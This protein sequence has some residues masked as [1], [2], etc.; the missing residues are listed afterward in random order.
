MPDFPGGMKALMDYLSKNVKYPA[1]AHAILSLIHI[2]KQQYAACIPYSTGSYCNRCSRW[3]LHAS[4]RSWNHTGTGWSYQLA[5]IMLK[6]LASDLYNVK[7]QEDAKIWIQRLFNWR[8]TF[9]EFL[10]EMTVS[11]THLTSICTA[12][13]FMVKVATNAIIIKLLRNIKPSLL[14]FSHIY[15][16]NKHNLISISIL[17]K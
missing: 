4:Q 8:V 6:D 14:F 17:C 13:T 16:I 15:N 3:L 10:S 2:S 7:T 11:Y 5:G 12:L 9:K 1:E